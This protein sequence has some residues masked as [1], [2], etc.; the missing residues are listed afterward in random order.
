MHIFQRG[1]LVQPP[2]IAINGLK[3]WL[4]GGFKYFWNFHPEPLGNDPI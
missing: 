2:T 4:A 1:W 3:K